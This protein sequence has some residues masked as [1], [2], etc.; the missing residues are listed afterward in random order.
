M[1]ALGWPA[2]WSELKAELCCGGDKTGP[3]AVATRKLYV[4]GSTQHDEARRKKINLKMLLELQ[5]SPSKQHERAG[6]IAE[7]S[8]GSG[9]AW[10]LLAPRLSTHTH[11]HTHTHADFLV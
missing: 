10:S 4:S 1:N 5:S 3:L 9:N 2:H 7:V 11:T 8:P 6:E